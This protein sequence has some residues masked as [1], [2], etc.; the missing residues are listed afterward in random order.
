VISKLLIANRGEIAVRIIRTCRDL[1]VATVAIYSDVDVAAR[2]VVLA[3]ERVGLPGVRATDTYLNGP[4]VIHAALDTGADAIHPGYGFLAESAEFATAVIESGMVWVGPPPEAIAALGDKLAARRIASTAGVPI[5]PG[6]LDPVVAPDAVISFGSQ[7]GYPLV[8]KA[9]AGGGGRG[10]KIVRDEGAVQDAFESARRE[11]RAYF[12]SDDV[13]VERYLS[14]SKHL[15]V[16]I[17]GVSNAE[18]LSLGVRDCSLQRRHQKL[19]E[20]TPA[21]SWVEKADEMGSA[22]VNLAVAAGYVNAG[23]VELLGDEDGDFYFLEVNSRLQVEH[24][25]TEEVY[26]IDLVACQLQIASGQGLGLTQTDLRPAGHSIECRINAE[27]PELFLPA[28]GRLTRFD[29]P[30]GPGV[31]VDAGYA[32]GDMVPGEYDSLIAKV[33]TRGVDREHAVRRMKRALREFVIEGVPTTIPVHLR[34]LEDADF[35]RGQH[36]TRT[37]EDRIEVSSDSSLTAP[38]TRPHMVRSRLW[39]PAMAAA[40]PS[41]SVDGAAEMVA[42]LQG[43]ILEVRVTPGDA[44]EAGDVLVVLE[45]M[46]METVLNAPFAGTATEVCAERGQPVGAGDLLVVIEP[47]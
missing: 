43:T 26:D 18:V 36:T 28:P 39:N 23:T 20:E 29:P 34:L 24:T 3:D 19:I 27:D 32:A 17:L 33:I 42:P 9:A 11:A 4:A 15:E 8:I 35:R 2:H 38:G 16:Q 13:Y 31:R 44:V 12:G 10:L 6:L 30:S 40:A 14:R 41:S 47:A 5:V 37:I 45:A 1:D 7:H 21:P 46:K 22:A 25:V